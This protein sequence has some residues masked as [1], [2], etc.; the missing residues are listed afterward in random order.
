M[1]HEIM[2]YAI[3]QK[4]QLGF[5]VRA[6]PSPDAP[7]LPFATRAL[8]PVCVRRKRSRSANTVSCCS[9]ATTRVLARSVPAPY[10]RAHADA[11][12]ARAGRAQA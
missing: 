11:P 1:H 2:M 6:T 7:P 10:P 8:T 5:D 9:R 4:E 12:R 3:A